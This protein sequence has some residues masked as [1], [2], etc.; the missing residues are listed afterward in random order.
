MLDLRHEALEGFG[1]R[2]E[3]L[4]L[5]HADELSQAA[6]MEYFRYYLFMPASCEPGDFQDY[7]RAVQ[8]YPNTL[9]YAV[10]RDGK[11]IG[12]SCYLDIRA[13]HRGLEIG[14]TWIARE[15][16]GTH[17]NP[18]MK[19]LMIRHAFQCGAVRVQ[20]KMDARNEHSRRAVAKLG[21]TYEGTLR[22]HMIQPNGFVRDTVMFSILEEEWPAVEQGL[23]QR[24]N[25]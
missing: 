12:M 23:L 24:L 18:A 6:D 7:I 15:H 22:R 11:A 16:W 1:I 9:A 14:M 4:D 5:R 13:P 10:I 20:I 21:A 25:P 19:L 3:P 17:V 2:L 8:A